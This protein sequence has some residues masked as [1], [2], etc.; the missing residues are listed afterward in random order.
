MVKIND[1]RADVEK[2]TITDVENGTT[3][4]H[5]EFPILS[6]HKTSHHYLVRDCSFTDSN[7][8]CYDLD[9]KLL[10]NIISTDMIFSEIINDN[11]I[12][13]TCEQK[14]EI[15]VEVYDLNSY[16]L[17]LIHYDVLKTINKNITCYDNHIYV[18]C[19]T[20]D[21][22]ITEINFI[23]DKLTEKLETIFL[24]VDDPRLYLID[25][26]YIGINID[27]SNKIENGILY[28]SIKGKVGLVDFV[29]TELCICEAKDDFVILKDG[30]LDVLYSK[31]VGNRFRRR[32]SVDIN[33][34]QT[35]I[36]LSDVR[37]SD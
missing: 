21:I 32:I 29:N 25:N 23:P 36:L 6:I 19:H 8:Y 5:E 14:N 1:F 35:H 22:K 24:P 17:N 28:N 11:L 37:F 15:N 31:D 34:K 16:Y 10:K 33:E 4:S 26:K 3:F 13:F 7:L 20:S 9:G 18:V 27:E 2:C 12:I 30:K